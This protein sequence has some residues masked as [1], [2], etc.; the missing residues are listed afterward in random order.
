MNRYNKW[1]NT[2]IETQADIKNKAYTKAKWTNDPDDWR[3]FRRQ[4]NKYNNDIKSA[5]NIYYYNKF[6]IR[7][8]KDR[9]DI[10]LK[11]NLTNDNKLWTTVKDMTDSYNK[12]PPRNI[13]H[14]NK[15]VTSLRQIANIA[16]RHYIDKIDKIRRD[17]KKH[18]LTHI[19]ILQMIIP[20]LKSTFKLP[21]ITLDQTIRLI[22]D[23]KTS[24]SLGHDLSSI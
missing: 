16:N 2:D 21:Y 1:Y 22:L 4:R 12:T 19:D 8:K 14:D 20:K 7:D 11:D 23:M 6:T 9:N 3:D 17:F 15:L 13:Y 18:R 10:R 5:K 24:N